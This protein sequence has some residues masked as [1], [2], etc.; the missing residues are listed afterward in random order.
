M[1]VFGLVVVVGLC[2]TSS[3]RDNCVLF[4]VIISDICVRNLE[5]CTREGVEMWELGYSA[6]P[7]AS[8]SGPA[9]CVWGKGNFQ[10]TVHQ[11]RFADKYD[12]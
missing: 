3:S 11:L 12:K 5:G 4:S 8:R 7:H 6:D 10:A 1:P 9:L 2:C